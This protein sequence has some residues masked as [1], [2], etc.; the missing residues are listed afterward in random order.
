M[1]NFNLNDDL[2]IKNTRVEETF[3]EVDNWEIYRKV[4][5]GPS[6]GRILGLDV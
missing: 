6:H 2:N 5:G 1:Y 4:T 3:G